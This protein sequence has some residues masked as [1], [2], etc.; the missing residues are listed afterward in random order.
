V[1]ESAILHDKSKTQKAMIYEAFLEEMGIGCAVTRLAPYILFWDFNT[2]PN[3]WRFSSL[4]FLGIG[5]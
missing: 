5:I 3:G 1:H 4:L 2:N